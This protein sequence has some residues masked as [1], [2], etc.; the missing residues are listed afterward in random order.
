MNRNFISL[1]VKRIKNRI[2]L[3]LWSRVLFL[4][5]LK[6]DLFRLFPFLNRIYRKNFR[7]YLKDYK[8]VNNSFVKKK[9]FGSFIFYM[10][11]CDFC[12]LKEVV[13]D[14]D[15]FLVKH[16]LPRK[17]DIVLDLGAGVGDYSILSSFKVKNG[18]VISVEADKFAYKLLIKNIYANKRSNVVP[19]NAKIGKV[20]VDEIVKKLKLHRLDLIKIDIE[21]WEYI[22]LC[23]A[24]YSLKKFKPKIII[25]IHSE[26]LRKKIIELLEHFGY[27]LAYEK[28]KKEVGFYLSYFK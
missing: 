24:I 8:K 7:R 13:L 22:A 11:H 17:K 27:E 19:L 5:S 6:R 21:G 26:R 3:V 23:G 2:S 20:K 15:Y 28:I 9:V 25:E 16:F 1:A 18:K 10:R 12:A 4:F 14:K